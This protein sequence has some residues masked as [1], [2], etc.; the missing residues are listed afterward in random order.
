MKRGW[1]PIN[2][3][4]VLATQMMEGIIYAQFTQAPIS[5]MDIVDIVV[6]VIM[7][8]ILLAEAYLK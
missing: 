3:F 2:R 8:C 4:K 1:D 5:D 7:Q 6:E